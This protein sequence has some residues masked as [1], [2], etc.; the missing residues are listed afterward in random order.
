MTSVLF[1]F[2]ALFRDREI[3]APGSVRRQPDSEGA[4]SG[5][6]FQEIVAGDVFQIPAFSDKIIEAHRGFLQGVNI[7]LETV[8]VT[9]RKHGE[10]AE[11]LKAH[12]W[13]ACLGETLTWVRIP[14]SPPD[15]YLQNT[16]YL[17]GFRGIHHFS[18]IDMG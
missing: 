15:S 13:K 10:M 17:Y 4:I 3:A 6:A 12:A 11:W 1:Q 14:L 16:Q 2:A 8:R 9:I 5:Y 18:D 7:F